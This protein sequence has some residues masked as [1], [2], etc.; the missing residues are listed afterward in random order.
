MKHGFTKCG[1]TRSSPQVRWFT[2]RA[3]I[4]ETTKQRIREGPVKN[5]LGWLI[6]WGPV[7]VGAVG[8][9][10]AFVR[11]GSNSPFLLTLLCISFCV[12][13][14]IVIHEL[15]HFFVGG[16]VELH[17]WCLSIGHG[18]IVFDK[19]FRKFRLILRAFPYSGVVYPFFF[20]ADAKHTRSREFAMSAAGPLSNFVL[21]GLGALLVLTGS[22][23]WDNFD[24][25]QPSSVGIYFLIANAYILFWSLIPYYADLNGAKVPN[26]GMMLIQLFFGR[27]PKA[28]VESSN[29]QTVT[30]RLSPSWNLYVNLLDVEKI[31]KSIR[32]RLA[33]PSLPA[34]DRHH[35]LDEFATCVLIYGAKDN[36]AE[37][38]I[39]ARE[40]FQ[41]KPDEWTV[42]ATYGSVL[43][44]NGDL[45]GGVPLLEE[46]LKNGSTNFDRAF[47]AVSLGL[48]QLRQ[49][50]LGAAKEWLNKAR[51]IDPASPCLPRLDDLVKRAM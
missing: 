11:P 42:K 32:E 51:E 44:E 24:V 23:A 27:L 22:N 50:Q 2:S 5:W 39:Y 28:W 45:A 20:S 48:A 41:S 30:G 34:E 49:D 26:D 10:F 19:E 47:A 13:F 21:F 18:D 36:L 7:L 40:L 15:G 25:L 1:V 29:S 31:L 4:M 16:L 38:L 35:A 6:G 43:V 14:S 8:V 37:A 12:A 33:N 9:I 3:S 46:V 17:P